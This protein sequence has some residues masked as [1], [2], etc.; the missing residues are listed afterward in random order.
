MTADEVKSGFKI[1]IRGLWDKPHFIK[2]MIFCFLAVCVMGF[3]VSWQNLTNLGTDPY[4][5]TNFGVSAKLGMSFGNWQ[6]ILNIVLFVIVFIKEKKNIGFGTLF[7]MFLVGYA[8]DITTW[9][10]QRLLPD[11]PSGGDMNIALR[12]LIAVVSLA[13]FVFAAAVYMSVDLGTAPYDA[14]SFV[15][16][17]SQHK[18]S[19]RVVRIIWDCA[20]TVVGFLVGGQAGIITILMAFT[21]GP[22]TAWV[23]KKIIRF[24]Q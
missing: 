8:C 13:I 19:F 12:L 1:Y 7:N 3:C 11:L 2:R 16:A 22:V 20:F 17:N 14:L 24:I 4:S 10:R 18:L 15:I 21:I 23:S 6:A 9:A 5:A